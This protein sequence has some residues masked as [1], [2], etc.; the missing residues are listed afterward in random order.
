MC[1]KISRFQWILGIHIKAPS[2]ANRQ[3]L[4]DWW[5]NPTSLFL[6]PVGPRSD[7][8]RNS[9]GWGIRDKWSS[10]SG[11]VLLAVSIKWI[12]SPVA[13]ETFN[14]STTRHPWILSNRIILPNKNDGT[15]KELPKVT[16]TRCYYSSGG[17]VYYLRK[18]AHYESLASAD[19]AVVGVGGGLRTECH[20]QCR[21]RRE[22]YTAKYP[23]PCEVSSLCVCVN[24]NKM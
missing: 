11:T 15:R 14:Q 22:E 12:P 19:E 6:H 13:K 3:L 20:K 24:K 23:T 18:W 10:I 5:T 16:L 2:S 7:K 8:T 9:A 21:T 1:F 4:I 17:W